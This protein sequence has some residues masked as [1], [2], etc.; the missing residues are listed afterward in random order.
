MWGK[1]VANDSDA[2]G[3]YN[4]NP[5]NTWYWFVFLDNT[6]WATASAITVKF[7]V[8]IVYYT[9]LERK[10]EINES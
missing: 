1:E 8:K 10:T 3:Q 9:K 5:V 4:G 2:I 7:D 6:T